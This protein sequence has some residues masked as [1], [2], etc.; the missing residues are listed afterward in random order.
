MHLRD[1][2]VALVD[3]DYSVRGAVARLLRVAGLHV[4]AYASGSEFLRELH[5]HRPDCVLLDMHMPS[6]SGLEVQAQLTTRSPPPPIVFITAHDDPVAERRG[7]AAGAFACL[8]KPV[9]EDLLLATIAD[10]VA[11]L[12]RPS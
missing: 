9:S 8:H 4:D 6:M 11:T 7:R 3:D 10:A 12:Q 2:K 5:S 1:V